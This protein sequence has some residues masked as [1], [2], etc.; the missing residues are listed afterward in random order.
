MGAAALELD[1]TIGDVGANGVKNITAGVCPFF[2]LLRPR[3]RP[4]APA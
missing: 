1:A 4:T 2:T 3:N